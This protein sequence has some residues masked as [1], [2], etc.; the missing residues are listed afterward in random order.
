MTNIFKN[1]TFGMVLLLLFL[2]WYLFLSIKCILIGTGKLMNPQTKEKAKDK[3]LLIAGIIA[4]IVTVPSFCFV[5]FMFI[6][7]FL[8]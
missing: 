6:V 5:V 4:G 1:S 3:K 8:L 7:V 2:A